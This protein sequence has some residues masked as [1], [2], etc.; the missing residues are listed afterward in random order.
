VFVLAGDL[1]GETLMP[2][3]VSASLY[4]AVSGISG[5]ELVRDAI[6]AAGR[7]GV[8]IARTEHGVR[9]ELI[10]DKK[11]YSYLGYRAIAVE[12]TRGG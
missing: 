6:D 2:P 8:A 1:V 12:D 7:H 9:R 4:R 10:F 11:T 3:A 5:V